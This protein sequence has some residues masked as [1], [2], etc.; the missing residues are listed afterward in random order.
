MTR[1]GRSRSSVLSG[2]AWYAIVAV[3]ALVMIAALVFLMRGDGRSKHSTKASSASARR[4]GRPT[5]P[6]TVAPKSAAATVSTT[7]SVPTTTSTTDPLRGGLAGRTIVIDPGHNG[8]NAAAS[9]FIA[10]PIWIGTQYRAC[11]TTGTQTSD[12]YPEHAYTLDVAQRLRALLTAA[13]ATVVMTRDTDTGVGPCIDQRAYIGNRAHAEVAIS[14]HADGGPPSGRGFHVNMPANIPGYTN[15]IYTASAILGRD[16]RDTFEAGT[17][18]PPSNY[19]GSDGLVERRDF[20]GL[21][22]SDVPKVLMETA[23]MRNATEAALLENPTFRQRIA[24]AL[25]AGLARYVSGT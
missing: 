9:S 21:N 22:L 7:T 4:T 23:N 6:T 14:I 15:D 1:T 19:I 8:G 13:G 17:G 11:D 10:R 24:V 18:L 16:L 5:L 20:G 3:A 12:G 2:N 25:E